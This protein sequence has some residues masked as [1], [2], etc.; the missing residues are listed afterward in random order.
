MRK[1]A[2]IIRRMY[3]NTEYLILVKD[4]RGVDRLDLTFFTRS[5]LIQGC[6]GWRTYI[7]T[8]H[9]T[10]HEYQIFDLIKYNL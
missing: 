3:I 9:Y 6:A 1:T 5:G 4:I 10:A 8:T 7:I 2:H